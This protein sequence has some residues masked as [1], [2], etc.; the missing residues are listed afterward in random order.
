MDFTITVDDW[1]KI[2]ESEYICLNLYLA[3]KL[4]KLWKMWVTMIQILIG[5]L[6]MVPKC[7]GRRIEELEVGGRIEIVYITT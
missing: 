7:L 1:M 2:K 3:E 6:R 4:R 5:A